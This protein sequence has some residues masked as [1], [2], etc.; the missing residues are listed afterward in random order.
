MT[1]EVFTH[2]RAPKSIVR[3]LAVFDSFLLC[4][5]ED[6][7]GAAKMNERKID[8]WRQRWEKGR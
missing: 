5:V 7:S 1:N 4:P 6:Y 3:G 2:R 8:S